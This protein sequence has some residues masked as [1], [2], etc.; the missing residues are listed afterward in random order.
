[1]GA[2]GRRPLG[3]KSQESQRRQVRGERVV[4]H[5]RPRPRACGP[6][7]A[8]MDLTQQDR[9]AG[10]RRLP[11]AQPKRIAEGDGWRWSRIAGAS[12]SF[13][14]S[15]GSSTATTRLGSTTPRMRA[16]QW[17]NTASED[18]RTSLPPNPAPPPAR[19][20]EK[21]RAAS[22]V[23]SPEPAKGQ[24]VGLATSC[25]RLTRRPAERRR[26]R[27]LRPRQDRPSR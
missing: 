13:R 20:R 8:A 22:G 18:A 11:H 15:S 9:V 2:R 16:L 26:R 17:S 27:G 21:A 7:P 3:T 25:R 10:L 19:S 12:S 14:A 4:S 5:G 1:M 24:M 23:S 6:D